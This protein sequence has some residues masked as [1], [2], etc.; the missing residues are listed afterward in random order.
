M[1]VSRPFANKKPEFE[2]LNVLLDEIMMRHSITTFIDG[3]NSILDL[4]EELL[5]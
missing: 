5:N 3:G 1:R 4:L 2:L